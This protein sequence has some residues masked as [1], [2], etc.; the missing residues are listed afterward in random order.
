MANPFVKPIGKIGR[1]AQAQAKTSTV[2]TLPDP[3]QSKCQVV[4]VADG[5]AGSPCHAVSD[6][7]TWKRVVLGT[8]VSTTA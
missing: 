3:T 4:Y 1:F 6:G 5:A 8:A 7:T 2:A